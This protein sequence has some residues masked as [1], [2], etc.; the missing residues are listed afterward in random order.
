MRARKGSIQE[1]LTCWE[2]RGVTGMLQEKTREVGRNF[3]CCVLLSKK[4]AGKQGVTET[5]AQG[6]GLGCPCMSRSGERLPFYSVDSLLGG[7]RE[8]DLSRAGTGVCH[9][10]L[11]HRKGSW[12]SK[13]GK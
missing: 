11:R 8:E 13:K 12:S 1:G 7:D 2:K 4:G 5:Y 9:K 3:I 10:V 6:M